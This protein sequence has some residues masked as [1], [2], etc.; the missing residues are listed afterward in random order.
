M[1]I[2]AVQALNVLKR[3]A[4]QD[5]WEYIVDFLESHAIELAKSKGK[6]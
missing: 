3:I 6:L 1:M 4:T 5:D 2:R